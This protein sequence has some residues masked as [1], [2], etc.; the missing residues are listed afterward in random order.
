MMGFLT[1]LVAW[2]NGVL[3]PPVVWLNAAANP[4][5]RWLL[6]PIA[7]MPGWLSATL[8][9]A[10]TGVF[11]LVVFKY[12]S[13][14]RAIK[15]VRDD[16]KAN[17]LALKLFK[18]SAAV[19]V[20]SQ[21]R[22]LAG[23]FWLF[24]LA[25]VP[26]AVMFVPALLILCQLSLWYQQRP[27]KVGEEAVV[28]MKFNGDAGAPLPKADLASTKEVTKIKRG[29]VYSQREIWFR[30]K[31]NENGTHRLAFEV[32]GRTVE[33]ELAV[34][35]GFMRVSVQR[36]GWDA[37]DVLEYPAESPFGPD[38]PVR[39]I[40]IAYPKRP[41]KISGTDWWIAYWFVASMVGGFLFRGVLK[42]NI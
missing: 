19:A 3:T 14:Q 24:V 11:M 33:K 4:L 16:I 6:A 15:R 23:A 13:N 20:Q 10:V 36:P 26:M 12:T 29:H 2:L 8:V 30:I 38:S 17:L 27:L 31:P 35:D 9:A 34:G 28:T 18:D 22:L 1:Q 5:G 39:S 37:K 21:E 32:D 42:V 41:S 40:E 7:A 25:L